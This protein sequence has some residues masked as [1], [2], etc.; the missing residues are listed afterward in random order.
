MT[1][2]YL[3]NVLMKLYAI[4]YSLLFYCT[5][6]NGATGF[7]IHEMHSART[8]CAIRYMSIADEVEYTKIISSKSV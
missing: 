3:F 4:E 8:A 1:Y 2:N 5:K 6:P 7:L